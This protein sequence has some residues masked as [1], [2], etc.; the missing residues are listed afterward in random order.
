MN[1]PR[2]I[3]ITLLT[4][5][6][7]IVRAD[8]FMDRLAES[9]TFSTSDDHVRAKLSGLL[10]LEYYHFSDEA[11]GL[12]FT[13]DDSLLNPRL[14]LFFDAQLGSNIYLFAQARVDTGFNPSSNP[15]SAR[16]DEYAVR[17]TPWQDGRFNVQVG[18][19]ATIVGNFAERHLSWDNPFINAPLVYENMTGIYDS[20]APPSI[21]DF[22]AGLLDEKYDYNPVVWGPVYATGLSVS[23]KLGKFDYAAEIKNAGLSSRPESWS[24][25]DNGFDRP[26][27][28]ARIGYR[29]DLAWKFG[30]SV[31][32]GAYF[33]DD[34]L[35]GLPRGTDLNDFKEKVIAQDISF[36]WRHWQ[37]WA[38]VYEARFEVPLVGNADTLGYYLEAKYKFTP[39]CFGALRWNQQ[40][41]DDIPN[42]E[43][44]TQPW[45]HDLWRMDAALTYRFTPHTQLKLQYSLQHEAAVADDTSH[46][47]AAQFTLRF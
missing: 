24:I 40:L 42:G 2:A 11:P 41:F 32:E 27:I 29:P 22:A 14:T 31:S 35:P 34:A 37:F 19:F 6:T 12:I 39:Q 23:G 46:L 17:W 21:E 36:A 43:G 25:T 15:I 13:E 16:L 20:E 47:L 3:C 18:Q 8:D 38:E 1:L 9:L 4:M 26:T 45:G 10:D 7:V 5:T 28:S 44:S 33:T 30:L